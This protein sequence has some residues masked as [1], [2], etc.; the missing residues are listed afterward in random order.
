MKAEYD[1]HY[2]QHH[3]EYKHGFWHNVWKFVSQ[4][5]FHV[6]GI[7]GIGEDMTPRTDEEYK[8]L[9]ELERQ[10]IENE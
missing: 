2:M 9:A 5:L 10:K 1:N 8:A 7:G 6:I 3:Y 4:T